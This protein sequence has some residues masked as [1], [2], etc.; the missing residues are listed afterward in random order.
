MTTTLPFPEARVSL[1]PLA[2]PAEHGGW[3]F[4]LEPIAL[5]LAVRPSWG[6][7]LIAAAF[8]FGFLTRQPLR[9]ALQDRMRGKSYPRTRWCWTFAMAYAFAALS[10][11]AAAVIIGGWTAM[12]PIAM[13]V[14]LGVTPILYD[15]RN[16]SRALLPELGG[17]VALTSSAAA[18]AAAGGMRIVPALMLS[19]VMVARAIP[20]IVFVRTLLQ[21]AHGHTA[22]AWPALSLHA[23]AIL[24]VAIYATKL[25]AVAMIVLFARA[26]WSLARRVARAKTIGVREI[27]YGAMTVVLAAI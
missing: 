26:V 3:G 10:A 14:P 2:L 21:R 18:I 1:R 20:A 17:A 7:V 9:L 8:A 24:L 16:R 27:G 13:V 12:V 19:G 11:L 5:G 23:I 4:L 15:T 22:S 25:A 6:G